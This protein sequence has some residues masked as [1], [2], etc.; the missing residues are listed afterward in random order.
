M[1]SC[2]N[3]ITEYTGTKINSICSCI[4]V[5]AVSIYVYGMVSLFNGIS[6]F[7]GYLMTNTSF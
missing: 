5:N 4:N 3:I 1:Y 2:L 6:I 7:M